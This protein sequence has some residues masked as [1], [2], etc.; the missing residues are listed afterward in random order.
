MN[1]VPGVRKIRGRGARE[2][3]GEEEETTVD[4]VAK[5]KGQHEGSMEGPTE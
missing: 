3:D 2:S 1:G 4:R 5:E